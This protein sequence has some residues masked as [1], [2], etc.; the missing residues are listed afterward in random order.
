MT[1]ESTN[2]IKCWRSLMKDV[3]IPVK[4]GTATSGDGEMVMM[5]L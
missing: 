3:L 1:C 2:A 4:E 5:S